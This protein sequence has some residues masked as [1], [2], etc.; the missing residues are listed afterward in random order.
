MNGFMEWADAGYEWAEWGLGAA[1]GAGV[2]AAL[3]AVVALVVNVSCR[4]WIS[5][6]QMGWLWA[7]VL[8]RLLIPEAPA[9]PCS[10]QSVLRSN[11][12]LELTRRLSAER[13]TP[14]PSAAVIA[15]TIEA[16]PIASPDARKPA[17]HR[18]RSWSESSHR[19]LD[20]G[21]RWHRD[22]SLGPWSANGDSAAQ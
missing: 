18:R 14:D 10:L 15:P 7:F 20:F 21:S 3:L 5:A 6:R 22:F 12:F 17:N 19:F 2:S 4:R 8:V 11:L 16:S 9:S 13:V 1:I